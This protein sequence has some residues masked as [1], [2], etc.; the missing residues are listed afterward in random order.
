MGQNLQSCCHRCKVKVFHFRCK[1]NETLMPFYRFHSPC[2][3][4]DPKSVET[5]ADQGQEADWMA[6]E[7]EGGYKNQWEYDEETRQYKF[8]GKG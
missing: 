1:E 7:A 6:D 4:S 3:R 5:L 2:I 8:L